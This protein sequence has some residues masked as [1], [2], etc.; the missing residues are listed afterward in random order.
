MIKPQAKAF[1]PTALGDFEMYAFSE[2]PDTRMP[3]LVLKTPNLNTQETVNVRI[4]S[5]CITGDVFASKRCDCGAQLWASLE[6]IQKNSGLLIYHRQEGRNIGIIEKLKAYNLQD[7]GMDTAEA[8]IALGHQADARNYNAPID[9]LKHFNITAINL[10]T[11]NPD[12]MN[13][14]EGSGIKVEKR[15]PLIT[16]PTEENKNYLQTKRDY[17]GHFLDL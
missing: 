8:N 10:L 16:T 4:H 17:F 11:N 14:F 1:V 5:E 7:Q 9:I 12:K 3:E 15:I 2:K 13:A 6:F